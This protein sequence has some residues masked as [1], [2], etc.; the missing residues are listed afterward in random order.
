MVSRRASLTSRTG[1]RRDSA[2]G[3]NVAGRDGAVV[4]AGELAPG[5]AFPWAGVIWTPGERPRQAVES[6]GRD[7]IRF[8]LRCREGWFAF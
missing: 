8:V 3:T 5:L 6:S 1:S 4:V 7:V 2:S